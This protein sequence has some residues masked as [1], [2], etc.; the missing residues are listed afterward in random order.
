MAI[1]IGFEPRVR[2]GIPMIRAKE[3]IEVTQKSWMDAGVEERAY[4]IRWVAESG[5]LTLQAPQPTLCV[6]ALE[7]G[8]RCELRARAD[9]PIDGEYFGSDALTF[10]AAGSR[11]AIYGAQVRQARLC[12]FTFHVS[13]VDYLSREQ[14]AS[15]ARL[16]TRYMFRNTP[17]RTCAALLDAD[18]VQNAANAPYVLSL[19]KAL[20]AAVLSM[21]VEPDQWPAPGSLTGKRWHAVNSY[22]RDHFSEPLSVA[23]LAAFVGMPPEEFGP[24][25]QAAT[26]MSLRQWQMDCRVRGAQRLLADE[27]NAG[28]ARVA[29]QC[30][31]QDQ[32][33]F[34]RAFFKVVGQTPS[35]WLHGRS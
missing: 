2:R 14:A 11:V 24:A 16:R 10:L 34:S 5:S 32:S 6:V 26:G 19:S 31:F 18:R 1:L 27:P 25:F 15:I 33:H 20:F 13:D 3:G 9:Q 28:L 4:N 21:A 17:V 35:A 22:L 7:V 30:G 23:T 12:C 29:A 8:G